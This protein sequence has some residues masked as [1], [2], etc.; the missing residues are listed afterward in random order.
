MSES[1]TGGT[2]QT[3][4]GEAAVDSVKLQESLN[5]T[6]AERDTLKM[7][8]RDL[9]SASKGTKALQAQYD[10]LLTKHSTLTEEFDGYKGSVK[11]KAIDSHVQTALDASGAHN[12]ARVKAMLDMSKVKIADDGTV[13]VASLAAVITTLKESDPYLFKTGEAGNAETSS[14]SSPATTVGQLPGVKP[15]VGDKT[16]DAFRLALDA[17][18]KAKDPFKAIEEVIAKYGK[19]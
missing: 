17:A 13:D 14:T 15:A 19:R 1:T 9:S 8:L 2:D 6:I 5:A 12:A 16:G 10:E 18:K 7:Q 4:T 3:V 11:Q